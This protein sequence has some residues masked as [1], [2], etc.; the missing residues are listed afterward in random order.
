M[1]EKE[2]YFFWCIRGYGLSAFVRSLGLLGLLWSAEVKTL[3]RSIG[4]VG[5]VGLVGER[6]QQG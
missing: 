4:L 6:R 1:K 5:L 3:V 2:N